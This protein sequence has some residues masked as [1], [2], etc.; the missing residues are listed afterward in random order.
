VIRDIA[1]HEG[2]AA[3]LYRGLT[4]NLV[5]NSSSWAIYFLCYGNIKDAMRRLR[6]GHRGEE[7]TSWNYFAASGTAGNSHLAVT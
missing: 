7:L 1:Q 4:P 2:G 5:G 6:S 3:A